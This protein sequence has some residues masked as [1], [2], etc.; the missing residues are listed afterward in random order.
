MD[1][2]RPG[3]LDSSCGIVNHI[4]HAI[5]HTGA[6]PGKAPLVG[7][8]Q[9]RMGISVGIVVRLVVD[10]LPIGIKPGIPRRHH[11]ESLDHIVVQF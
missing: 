2:R 6:K 9:R 11:K 7:I 4:L 8:A 5:L 10:D 3:S 1:F